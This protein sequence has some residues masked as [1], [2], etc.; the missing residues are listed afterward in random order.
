[1]PGKLIARYQLRMRYG[2]VDNMSSTGGVTCAA[3]TARDVDQS[4]DVFE[5][6]VLALRDEGLIYSL[7]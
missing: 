2:G 4:T 5:T 6:T 7:G 3:H 1:M